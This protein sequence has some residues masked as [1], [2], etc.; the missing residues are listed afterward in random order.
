[1]KSEAIIVAA[2]KEHEHIIL[3]LEIDK[4]SFLSKIETTI[5]INEIEKNN[6]IQ[7]R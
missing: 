6:R 3:N 1:M 7:I 4:K 2:I 5:K